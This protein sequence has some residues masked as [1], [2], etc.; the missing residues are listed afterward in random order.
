MPERFVFVSHADSGD[1]HTLALS[2]GGVLLPLHRCTLGGTLMPMA[3]SPCGRWLYVARRS[4]PMAVIT[5]AINPLTGALQPLGEAPLPGS[6]AYLGADGSG[7]WLFAAA[8][9]DNL[10]SVSPIAANGLAG[11]AHQVLP[12]PPHAHAILPSPDQRWVLA[13]SL[14]GDEVRVFG[15][16]GHTG[17]LTP[18]P[19][20]V[21]QSPPQAGPRH[22]R[23]HPGGRFAYL[24]NE[25]DAT[26]TVLAFDAGT[27]TLQTVQTVATVPPGFQ[28][29]PWAADLH[30]TPDGRL[31]YTSERT[32]STLAAFAVNANTGQVQALGH[33]PTEACPRGFAITPNGQHLLAVGQLSH[34]LSHYRIDP[35][36]GA[37]NLRQRLLMGQNP[38][39]ICLHHLKEKP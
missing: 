21:W 13:T 29:K 9:Q 25:L 19:V 20:S 36:T 17:Q 11:A 32:S 16:D 8:Y 28:G 33:T 10:V 5:L 39:W 2:D 34:H 37:L 15:F 1:V 3:Q 24:L 4:E 14:G 35:D 12:T 23:F 7:R 30:L 18:Q 31:L 27:G 26:L 38:N 22:L 6:M